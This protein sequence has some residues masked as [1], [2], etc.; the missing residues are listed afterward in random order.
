PDVRDTVEQT[1]ARRREDDLALALRTPPG[2]AASNWRTLMSGRPRYLLA[3]GA[4][5]G[6]AAAAFA[7]VPAATGSSGKA[8]VIASSPPVTSVDAR[9]FLLTAAETATHGK[10]GTGRYW[11]TETLT[12]SLVNTVPGEYKA[13]V[14]AL[15]KE[16]EAKRKAARGDAGAVQAAQREFDKKLTDL[17]LHGD[18]PFAAAA[19]DTQEVWR[20][21]EAGGKNRNVTRPDPDYTFA[22][23]ED[24]AK[25]KAMGS[26]ALAAGDKSA[27]DDTLRRPL[28]I[29]NPGLTLANVSALPTGTAALESRLKQLYRDRAGARPDDTFA[30]YLWQT[31]SD[32]LTAPV[33]SGTRAALFRVMARQPGITAKS[34]VRDLL[35]RTGTALI[36]TGP[37][38]ETTRGRIEY[39]MIIDPASAQLLQIEM[40]DARPL[41]LLVQAFELM[42]WVDRLGAQ[43][44]T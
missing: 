13:K 29:S 9:S 1:Y 37:G 22:S 6:L 40:R 14:E 12:S 8:P 26:P 21:R 23:P 15:R 35:G 32:L 42:G 27:S 31:G 44:R 24:E 20:A 28:S 5:A 2:P 3:G 17:K 19:A 25:W 10:A 41:P 43:P 36:L 34:R 18:P 38:D 33:T 11:Y 30:T 16:L 7:V 4:V 39:R